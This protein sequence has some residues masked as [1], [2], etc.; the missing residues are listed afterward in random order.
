MAAIFSGLAGEC[1]RFSGIIKKDEE[2][3]ASKQ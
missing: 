3:L 2:I 1:W